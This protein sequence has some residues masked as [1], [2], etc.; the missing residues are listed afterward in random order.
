MAESQPLRDPNKAPL[1]EERFQQHG[2]PPPPYQQQG[3]ITKGIRVTKLI[4][5]SVYSL[6]I[7]I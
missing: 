5:G 2:E 3:Q 7:K 1:Q 4:W 6:K